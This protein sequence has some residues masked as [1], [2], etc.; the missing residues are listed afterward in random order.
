MPIIQ[1]NKTAFY[2]APKKNLRYFTK[3]KPVFAKTKKIVAIIQSSLL[4]VP[5][6]DRKMAVFKFSFSNNRFKRDAVSLLPV[7]VV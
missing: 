4:S 6:V 2:L 5:T 1:I 7:Y 3:N